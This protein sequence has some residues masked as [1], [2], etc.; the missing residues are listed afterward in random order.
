MAISGGP[1]M[2]GINEV[3]GYR[4][5]YY[6]GSPTTGLPGI[7]VALLGRNHPVGAIRA[8][9]FAILARRHSG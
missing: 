9:L 1:G 6:D 4:H 7:A 5:R 3:L 8:L 2:V